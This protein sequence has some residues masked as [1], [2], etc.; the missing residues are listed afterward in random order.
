MFNFVSSGLVDCYI[1]DESTRSWILTN[2]L[3]LSKL[4]FAGNIYPLSLIVKQ[5]YSEYDIIFITIHCYSEYLINWAFSNQQT[6]IN[7]N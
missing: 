2:T 5:L 7:I 6:L 4:H 3:Q 1:H